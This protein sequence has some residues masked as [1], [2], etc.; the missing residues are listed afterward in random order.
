M[1]DAVVLNPRERRQVILTLLKSTKRR[2]L[3]SLFRCDDRP[4]VQGI[5]AA[6]RRGVDVRV[7]ITP[8]A[9]GWN[10]R[11][12]RLTSELRNTGVDVRQYT[13]PWAK[14]HAKYIVADRAAMVASLNYTQKCFESTCDFIYITSRPE[15]VSS[16]TSLFEYDWN[17]SQGLAPTLSGDLI[18]SPSGSLERF[19][20]VLETAR[21]QI[22][23]IDH[24]VS[25]PKVLLVIARKMMEG[26]RI[27]ILGRG[28][29]GQLY[30]HGKMVL[31]DDRV[32]VVGSAS[33]SRQCLDGRREVSV[34]IEHAP[35]VAELGRFFDKMAKLEASAK[36]RDSIESDDDDDDDDDDEDDD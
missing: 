9:R 2:I 12:A 35:I 11:L 30:S 26:V 6:A 34:V 23:F 7:L 25:H 1:A 14:Y 29:L 19:L 17:M 21:T 28:D 5:V 3:F 24:R 22:R 36:R 8:R 13:G 10:K 4:V 31:V 16:L 33:L 27:R 32:A 15:L 20:D 18:V